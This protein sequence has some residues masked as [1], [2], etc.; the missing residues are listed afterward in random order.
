MAENTNISNLETLRTAHVN[1]RRRVTQT[2]LDI[3]A[4]NK[5]HVGVNWGQDVMRQQELIEAIDRAIADEKRMLNVL[6]RAG[7]R[8]VRDGE[9]E[10]DGF[11][12]SGSG[13]S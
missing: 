4:A 9:K 1:E 2:A 8:A 11:I 13:S 10:I 12:V 3:A 5:S 7:D 6:P